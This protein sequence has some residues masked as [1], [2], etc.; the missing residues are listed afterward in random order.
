ML[1]RRGI[2]GIFYL[3][4]QREEG[5]GTMLAHAWTQ[6]GERILTGGAGREAFTVVSVFGWEGS[7]EPEEAESSR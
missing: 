3:G 1:E 7:S 5:E 6:C 2:P 4:V